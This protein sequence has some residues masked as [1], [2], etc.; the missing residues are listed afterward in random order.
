[1][2]TSLTPEQ[3]AEWIPGAA[4]LVAWHG[5]WPSF[6][7]AEVVSIEL[8]RSGLSRV[9]VHAFQMTSAIG[10]TGHY[11]CEKHTVIAFLLDDIQNVALEGFNHQN[12]LSGLHITRAENTVE[13]SLLDIYGVSGSL[14]A[15]RL[16]LEFEPGIPTGS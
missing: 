16:S 4:E 2:K 8:H 9:H 14:I 6:H 3:I 11:V 10:A 5:R 7:D 13:V 1:M 15:K 12:V